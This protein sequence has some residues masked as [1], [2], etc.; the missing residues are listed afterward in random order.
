MLSALV[1]SCLRLEGN[2]FFEEK[3]TSSHPAAALYSYS[4]LQL[5]ATTARSTQALARLSLLLGSFKRTSPSSL[6]ARTNTMSSSSASQPYAREQQIAIAAVLKASLLAQKIQQELVGSGG[7]QKKDK[8][9][10]T[11]QSLLSSLPGFSAGGSWWSVHRRRRGILPY[12]AMG[13]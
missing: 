8:S 7:V 3:I 11:G 1:A 9:P 4:L 6:F 10:V 5:P 2:P 12:W 13:Q